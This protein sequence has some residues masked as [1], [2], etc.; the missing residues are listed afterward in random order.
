MICLFL[1]MRFYV[2]VKVCL[3]LCTACF[4]G[5]F[6]VLRSIFG[7]DQLDSR[8]ETPNDGFF[9]RTVFRHPFSDNHKVQIWL[10]PQNSLIIFSDYHKLSCTK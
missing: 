7:D 4:A 1:K 6:S 9:D 2:E 8:A 3:C 5:M 10:G